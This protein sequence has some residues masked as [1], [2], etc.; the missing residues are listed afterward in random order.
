MV[1]IYVSVKFTFHVFLDTPSHP[2]YNLAV[3]DGHVRAG[4]G[5]HNFNNRVERK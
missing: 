5:I 3:T 1:C 4:I 2:R